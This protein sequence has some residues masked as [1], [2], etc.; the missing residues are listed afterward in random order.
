MKYFV[1]FTIMSIAGTAGL[2]NADSPKNDIPV[3][4]IEFKPLHITVNS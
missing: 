1:I 4:Y 3:E 2:I